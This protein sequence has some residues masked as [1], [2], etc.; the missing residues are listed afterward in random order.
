MI[1][2][3]NEVERLTESRRCSTCRKSKHLAHFSGK[4][5]RCKVCNRE[6]TRWYRA[7]NGGREPCQ[8]YNTK[9]AARLILTD[10]DRAELKE[11]AR[12]RYRASELGKVT[13][14]ISVTRRKLRQQNPPSVKV[15]KTLARLL[16][17]QAKLRA[18]QEQRK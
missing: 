14:H 11:A 5:A 10:E 12:K 18:R 4:C 8:E 17:R 1:A 9:N 13:H 6:Y 7:T 3:R 2:F 15:Q 16:A